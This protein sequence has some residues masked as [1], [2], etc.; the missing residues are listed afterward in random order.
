MGNKNK[1]WPNLSLSFQVL[2]V[3][4]QITINGSA[5]TDPDFHRNNQSHVKVLWKCLDITA[6]NYSY[7]VQPKVWLV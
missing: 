4:F 1:F 6:R 7:G 5:S 3:S 2:S